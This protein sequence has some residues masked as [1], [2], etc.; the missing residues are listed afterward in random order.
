MTLSITTFLAM[1]LLFDSF[2][3]SSFFGFSN[4]PFSSTV[5]S[6]L[7]CWSKGVFVSFFSSFSELGVRVTM[8]TCMLKVFVD[9][10][11]GE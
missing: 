4:S 1:S 10:G 5:E 6:S 3:V 7:L 11:R 9:L 8:G 2:V